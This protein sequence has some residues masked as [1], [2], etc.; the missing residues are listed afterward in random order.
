M[1]DRALHLVGGYPAAH[2]VRAGKHPVLRPMRSRVIVRWQ[3]RWTPCAARGLQH[4]V[5]SPHRGEENERLSEPRSRNAGGCAPERPQV[6]AARRCTAW[7][8][9][10]IR[11]NNPCSVEDVGRR[12]ARQGEDV[13]AP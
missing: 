3:R 13:R 5:A 4:S 12:R 8:S 2:M 6:C 9:C 10:R 11:S 1:L 7:T